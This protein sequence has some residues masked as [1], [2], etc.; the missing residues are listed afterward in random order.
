MRDLTLEVV[1]PSEAQL[2][3][4]LPEWGAAAQRLGMPSLSW[5][6]SWL[7]ILA[8]GMGHEPYCIVA[9]EGNR[10]VGLLPLAFVRSLLFGRFLVG[11]PYVNVGGVRAENP[12]A[13]AGL[14][15]RAVELADRLDVRYLELRHEKP[16]DHAGLGPRLESKVHMRLPLPEAAD[17]LWAS[18]KPK[19]RNQ[20]RKGEKAGLSIEWG[21]IE[22]LDDFYDVFAVNMR[23]LGT[24][25]FS[26]RLFEEILARFGDDAELC[27]V[28]TPQGLPVAG[29]LLLHGSEMTEVPSASALRRYNATNA[30]MLMY[31]HLLCRA[32]ERGRPAFDFGRSTLQSNTYRF[33]RQ[34]G[35]EPAPAI[36]QYYV[37]RGTIGDVRPEN[38]R[39]QQ[40]IRIW[41]RLPVRLT[42]WI[43]PPIVRGIP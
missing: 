26:R 41:Q 2:E 15:D 33:K 18:F 16:L 40:L 36:W 42:R 25:V 5:H 22:R 27:I 21:G 3:A 30:N 4:R 1:R 12:A 10:I 29:S 39:Y 24:P 34:W 14:I 23:D 20:I 32:I 9:H 35:A 8:A 28:R 37:R 17:A 7:A 11:L 19:V 13:A 31:W 43:G 6:P 38:S